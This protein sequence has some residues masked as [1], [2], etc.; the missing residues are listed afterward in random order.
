MN[1]ILHYYYLHSSWPTEIQIDCIGAYLNLANKDG[2]EPFNNHTDTLKKINHIGNAIKHSFIN[3]EI[4]WKRNLTP[5]P[6]LIAFH[7]PHN[8]LVNPVNFYEVPLPTL[9]TEYNL[10]LEEYRHKL[11]NNYS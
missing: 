2:F 11:K 8:K 1:Y 6:Q 4:L 5:I 7:H 3:S 9:I 10:I